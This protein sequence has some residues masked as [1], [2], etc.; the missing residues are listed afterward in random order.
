MLAA[1]Q[2]W[3]RDPIAVQVAAS[4]P[5]L[6][7]ESVRGFAIRIQGDA[8]AVGVVDAQAPRLLAV[9]R[10]APQ[11]AINLTHPLT[12]HGRQFK[13]PLVELAEP[14]VEAAEAASEYFARFLVAVAQIGLTAEQCS[15]LFKTGPTRWVRMQ[16]LEVFNQTPGPGAGARLT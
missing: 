1:L 11:V 7:P 5:G 15:G 3:I 13:G 10:E 2:D 14:S 8:L 6:K 9:L 12:F 4:A 16:P